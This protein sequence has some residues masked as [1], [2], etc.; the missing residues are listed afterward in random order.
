MPRGTPGDA[1]HDWK[2]D[3]SDEQGVEEDRDGQDDA[4]LLGSERTGQG[5][6]QE[7]GDHDA[8]GGQDDAS[9][10]PQRHPHRVLRVV[11]EVVVLACGGQ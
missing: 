5:E 9:G 1:Q 3:E 4:H 6:G 8:G 11:G 10:C 2:H 7:H